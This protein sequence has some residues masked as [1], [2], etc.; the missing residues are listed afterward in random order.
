MNRCLFLTALFHAIKLAGDW[1]KR[2]VKHLVPLGS[3]SNCSMDRC[4]YT[5]DR[6]HNRFRSPR[7]AVSG[8]QNNVSG[9]VREVEVGGVEV[10]VVRVYVQN[11]TV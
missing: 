8:P 11:A 3:A 1:F 7:L 2:L 5:P 10:G 6:A 9:C 4:I